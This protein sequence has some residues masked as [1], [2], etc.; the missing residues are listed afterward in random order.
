M[1]RI[2]LLLL[3]IIFLQ[4]TVFATSFRGDF[5]DPF[6]NELFEVVAETS[7]SKDYDMGFDKYEIVYSE[8]YSKAKIVHTVVS[9]TGEV[10]TTDVCDFTDSETAYTYLADDP[11]YSDSPEGFNDGLIRSINPELEMSC[12]KDVTD[13]IRFSYLGQSYYGYDYNLGLLCETE[14][15]GWTGKESEEREYKTT[16][17]EIMSTNKAYEFNCYVTTFNDDGY[18]LMRANGKNY[19]VK[20]K[21][22]I[23]PTVTYNGEKISFD[24]IPVIENGRTLVPLRAIFEKLGASVEWD[25]TTQTVTAVKDDMKINLTV[26]NTIAKKNDETVSLDVPAKIINGRTLVPVRFV[27]DCFGVDVDWDDTMQRVLLTSK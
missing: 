11:S 5:L 2:L 17:T 6:N 16:I 8:D 7:Y 10:T 9:Y 26:N 25:D 18:A 4:H 1:K 27:A 13:T 21:K 3:V 19:V 12:Y 23:I 15:D 14:N 24:Q 20:L 22:G